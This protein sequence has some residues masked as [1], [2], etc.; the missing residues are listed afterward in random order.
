MTIINNTDTFCRCYEFILI[1]SRSKCS[2]LKCSRRR[3]LLSTCALEHISFFHV[4]A[5]LK[6]LCNHV[7]WGLVTVNAFLASFLLLLLSIFSQTGTMA[8]FTGDGTCDYL[9]SF[10]RWK[11]STNASIGQVIHALAWIIEFWYTGKVW[12][13]RKLRK[14][15]SRRSQIMWILEK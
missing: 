3:A 9:V 13:A 14:S 6:L 1:P 5:P 8:G 15:F 10:L 7:I 11:G 2:W 12:R 4:L